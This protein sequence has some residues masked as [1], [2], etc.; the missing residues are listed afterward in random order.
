MLLQPPFQRLDES[1]QTLQGRFVGRS[2][3]PQS[4]VALHRRIGTVPQAAIWF[5]CRSSPFFKQDNYDMDGSAS[6][7]AKVPPEQ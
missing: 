3:L 7:G 5:L 1:Q 4:F 2:A 6:T